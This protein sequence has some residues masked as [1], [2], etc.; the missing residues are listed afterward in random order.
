MIYHFS[1]FINLLSKEAQRSFWIFGCMN[2]ELIEH[3]YSIQ[4]HSIS[5]EIISLQPTMC[6][7]AIAPWEVIEEIGLLS[8]GHYSVT[9]TLRDTSGVIHDSKS[10]SF[11]VA[12]QPVISR[13]CITLQFDPFCP[14]NQCFYLDPDP[15]YEG[16]RLSADNVLRMLYLLQHL[17][18]HI[19]DEN[20][21][22]YCLT[23]EEGTFIAWGCSTIVLGDLNQDCEL[24]VIDAILLVRCFL[25]I[26]DPS[27]CPW[28]VLDYNEDGE[29]NILDAVCLINI[30]LDIYSPP[31]SPQVTPAV[32]EYLQSIESY[33]SPEDFTKL[34]ALL[35]EAIHVLAEYSL[36]QNCPNPFNSTTLIQYSVVSDHSLPHITL[37]IYNLLGQEVR[38]LAD[39]RKKPG[40][41]TATWDGRDS[42]GREVSS[43]IYFYRLSA[44]G[45]TATKRMVLMK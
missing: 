21:D 27:Q 6:L 11:S 25:E 26:A 13:G 3:S 43:G 15:G 23:T 30:I 16:H 12:G 34:M 22:S 7:T 31:G 9:A 24:N 17:N 37:K 36:S 8:V 39:E 1:I 29:I 20:G 40:Y 19:A 18:Y 4:G 38:T 10:S 5:I 14:L 2:T 41:Y 35:K 28:C 33:F 32:I 45:F 44:G 42:V